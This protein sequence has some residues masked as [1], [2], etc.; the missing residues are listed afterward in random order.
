M[1]KVLISI[2]FLTFVLSLL[3]QDGYRDVVHLKNGSIIKGV[4]VEQI[5]NKQ[6]KIETA[7]GSVF[8]YQM[9]EIEKM[10]KEQIG[11]SG[12]RRINQNSNYSSPT[13]KGKIIVSGS[14]SLGYSS[15]TNE[16]RGNSG[17]GGSLNSK[18]DI[19]Q[20]DFKP[21]IGWFIADGLAIAIIM[22]YTYTKQK[23]SIDEYS[24]SILMLGPSLAYYFGSS[25]IKPFI[26]GE[27]LFGTSK[28]D[29][30]YKINGW[31]LGAGIAF[32][33]NQHIS[34]DLG[35]GY[36]SVSGEND[37]DNYKSTVKGVAFMGGISVY[38]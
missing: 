6:L 7:D 15:M 27:Y 19:N 1:K 11:N 38:F 12:M 26:Q 22:D 21:S 9:D 13:A 18:E 5:P 14:S 29:S 35:L 4:I 10:A 37:D 17:Y 34:L 30:K 28:F 31:G 32:F 2:V 36:A 33:M 25:N 8:V 16:T 3:A 24:S 20:F 23:N